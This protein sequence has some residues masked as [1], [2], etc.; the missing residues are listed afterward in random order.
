MPLVP[1]TLATALQPTI[2]SA[3][4]A[5]FPQDTNNPVFSLAQQT[6]FSTAL[7]TGI[8]NGLVPYLI[9]QTVVNVP[10]HA[11]GGAVVGT[12]T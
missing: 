12:I 2:L 9:A 11:P 10:A 6:A 3:L 5:T 1:A 4:Q 7:A 8:A